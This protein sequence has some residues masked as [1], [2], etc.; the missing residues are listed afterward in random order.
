MYGILGLYMYSTKIGELADK[1]QIK[2]GYRRSNKN[3][4][5]RHILSQYG[6]QLALGMPLQTIAPLLKTGVIV[7]G[8]TEM[9]MPTS[10]AKIYLTSGTPL[11]HQDARYSNFVPLTLGAPRARLPPSLAPGESGGTLAIQPYPGRYWLH[12]LTPHAS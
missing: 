10:S 3:E 12:N 8:N 1:K 4:A 5:A 9:E 6:R 7:V 11:F 2:D